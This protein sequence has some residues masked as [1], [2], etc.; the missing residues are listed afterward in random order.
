VGLAAI[1]VVVVVVVILARRQD[2]LEA[3]AASA[4]KAP[5]P[6]TPIVESAPAPVVTPA[7]IPVVEPAPA[8]VVAPA[9][10]P[11]APSP[12]ARTAPL[13]PPAPSPAASTAPT[14]GSYEALL[15]EGEQAFGKRQLDRARAAFERAA[16]MRP[17]GG[18]AQRGIGRCLVQQGD[19]AAA[20][21]HFRQAAHGGVTEAWFDLGETQRVLSQKDDALESYRKY[22]G[23]GG[24]ARSGR[25]RKLIAELAQP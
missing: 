4:P 9:A 6:P 11:P 19:P 2:A 23:S 15:A 14:A 21:D 8:P 25:A 12:A 1:A 7:Q 10:A 17:N 22:L 24:G 16:R 3:V 18:A 13:A 5:P 20:A